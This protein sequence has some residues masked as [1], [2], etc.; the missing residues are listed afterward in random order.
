MSICIILNCNHK[1][2]YGN[3]CCKHKKLHLTKN[4]II[5]KNKFTYNKSDYL[6]EDIKKTL[7]D[8]YTQRNIKKKIDKLKKDDLFMLLIDEMNVLEKIILIQRH[9]KMYLYFIKGPGYKNKELY[10]KM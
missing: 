5:I 1:K 7:K 10:L 3:Y 6:K 8:F 9:L 2:K 4:N